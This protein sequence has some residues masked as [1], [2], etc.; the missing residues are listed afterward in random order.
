MY[1]TNILNILLLLI[2]PTFGRLNLTRKNNLA[3][4][5]GQNSGSEKDAQGPLSQY[6]DDA[7]IDIVLLAFLVAVKGPDDSPVINFANQQAGCDEN[8]KPF[9]CLNIGAHITDCQKKGK[10][11]LL[12][13]GGAIAGDEQGYKSEQDAQTGANMVW[14]MFGP[15]QKD[16]KTIRPFGTAMINGF[17][18]DFEGPGY[19]QK[20]FGAFS[21]QLRNLT[22]STSTDA[23]KFYLSAAPQC[24]GL[25]P[26]LKDIHFDMWFI[27]FYNNA[28]C[29]VRA[30]DGDKKGNPDFAQWN[31]WASGNNTKMFI[32]LPA[33]STAASTESYVAP[34][35]LSSFLGRAK[36]LPNMGGVSLWDATQS[37]KNGNYHKDVMAA[38]NKPA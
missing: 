20:Q 1:L 12:S 16:S 30:Y 33:N 32:G 2:C 11:V 5:W 17:D 38:L 18:L 22:N 31:D 7:D 27:Q 26:M 3:V 10:T 4:Y 28:Q 29:D 15:Q 35:D 8:T 21:K 37:F 23:P 9:T 25:S 6:C 13:I 34:N 36:T 14:A 24:P 19:E